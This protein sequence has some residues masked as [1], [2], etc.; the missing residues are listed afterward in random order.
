MAVGP[1][2]EFEAF[3]DDAV[4]ARRYAP[5]VLMTMARLAFGDSDLS[6]DQKVELQALLKIRFEHLL[7]LAEIG[8]AAPQSSQM[9]H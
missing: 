1:E 2:D 5:D 6:E 9:L 4:A 3:S 7:Y 8:L